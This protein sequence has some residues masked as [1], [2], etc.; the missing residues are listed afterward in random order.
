[1]ASLPSPSAGSSDDIVLDANLGLISSRLQ[2]NQSAMGLYASY[3][4]LQQQ[5]GGSWFC[6]YSAAGSLIGLATCRPAA[7]ITSDG[8]NDEGCCCYVDCFMHRSFLA[9]WGAL[10]YHATSWA[11]RQQHPRFSKCRAR[12]ASED[13]AKLQRFRA[14][15][16][17][18]A[19]ATTRAGA[20]TSPLPPFVLSNSVGGARVE[21]AVTELELMLSRPGGGRHD[22]IVKSLQAAAR[23]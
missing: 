18:D 22:G 12:V 8:D 13:P 2:P 14:A 9:E 21:V 5:L 16:F 6:A 17:V 7:A 3:E 20:A 1:M 11:S 23:L 10:L 19:T 4:H 15:A